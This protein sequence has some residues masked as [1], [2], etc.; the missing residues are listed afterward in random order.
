MPEDTVLTRDELRLLRPGKFF[1]DRGGF[2]DAEQSRDGSLGNLATSACLTFEEAEV[3]PQELLTVYEA[4]K[5]CLELADGPPAERIR[6]AVEEAFEITAS[7]LGKK[8]N[9]AIVAWIG[10]CLPFVTTEESIAAFKQH[11]SSLVQQYTL[12][13]GLKHGDS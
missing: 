7:L 2:G 3:A 8:V 9:S 5:Q 4:I 11:L 13:M 10:D 6:Q 1:K 12:V